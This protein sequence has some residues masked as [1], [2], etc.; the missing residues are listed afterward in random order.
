[1]L[2]AR[3]AL[4]VLAALIAV[5]VL[6]G[7]A[8]AHV[9]ITTQQAPAGKPVKLEL[10]IGHGCDG[11]ATT[12]L[13][14]QVPPQASGAKA[15]PTDG[16]QASTSG[17]TL[18]WKGGPLADH[19]VQTYPFRATLSGQKGDQVAFKSIQR[20]EGGA[21][22]A[23]IQSTAGGA[24]PEYPAP[25]VTLTS[26]AAAPQANDPADQQAAD[27]QVAEEDAAATGEPTA[28]DAT[29]AES[30]SSDDDGGDGKSLLL[31]VIAGLGIGTVAGIVV[32]ARRR[33]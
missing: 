26:T 29:S 17:S 7:T 13:V 31:I 23:W 2:N 10:E 18:T 6:S 22:T 21:S 27:D 15:L 8:K 9:E 28:T 4:V 1:M 3:R 19:D 25:A 32:R 14:V 16:W 12:S 33:N 5:P 20:C 30:S 11:A 24:E